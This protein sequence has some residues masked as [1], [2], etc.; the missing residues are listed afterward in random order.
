MEGKSFFHVPVKSKEE[1]Y[2][3]IMSD[4]KNSDYTNGIFLD[5][6]YFSKHYKLIAIDLSKETELENPNLKQKINF[7]SKLEDNSPTMFFIIEKS[8][9]TTFEVSQNSV[10]II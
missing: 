7:I 2:E 1:A 9:K 6:E 8:E 4:S 3:K 10:S 5:Y